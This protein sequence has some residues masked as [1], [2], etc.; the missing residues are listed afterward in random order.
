MKALILGSTG[1]LGNAVARGF[2]RDDSFRIKC[3]SRG[4]AGDLVPDRDR[5]VFDAV[6]H[7]LTSQCGTDYD[8]VINCIGVIKPF[9]NDNPYH[10]AYING[11]FPHKLALWAKEHGARMIH[12]TTDC[13]F[14]GK[15]GAYTE[16]SVHDEE[17]FYG[18][19]KS[20]G[21][22][23]NC[24]V[25]RTSMIGEEI[26]KHASLIAWVKSQ[27]GNTINGFTNHLWNGVTTNQYGEICKRI[28]KEGLYEEGLFHAFSPNPV[29]KLELVTAI[30]NRFDLG[31]T[32]NP[33]EANPAVDRTLS[34][35]RALNDKLDIP[36]IPQ[37]IERL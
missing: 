26:H 24:M 37:Q 22:P 2:S 27:A 36:E 17:D 19:S 28:I 35:N 31:I 18:R 12:I 3:S 20:L 23:S 25:L 7:D 29:N 34:T 4:R 1:M 16:S 11:A 10:S 9:I 8:Y 33:M 5:V 15:D 30:N 6:Q 32:I 13:V 14:S 21:E